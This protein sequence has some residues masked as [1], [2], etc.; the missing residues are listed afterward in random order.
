MSSLLA[1]GIDPAAI[2]VVTF[3]NRAGGELVE[4]LATANPEAAPAALDRNDPC[5]RT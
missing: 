5:V 1:E 3:S 2:L 4:R